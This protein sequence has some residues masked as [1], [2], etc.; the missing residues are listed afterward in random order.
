MRACFR[1][2]FF[3]SA[4]P[5]HQSCTPH[6][7]KIDGIDARNRN[8]A[9]TQWRLTNCSVYLLFCRQTT[10]I[11][12]TNPNIYEQRPQ[13]LSI[14]SGILSYGIILWSLSHD[15]IFYRKYAVVVKNFFNIL[16]AK[17]Q[18][19]HL[20]DS[21]DA[22]FL[23]KILIT[24]GN[25]CKNDTETFRHARCRAT[26]QGVL[27]RNSLN[28]SLRVLFPYDLLSISYEERISR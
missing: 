1:C 8:W 21:T 3:T 7:R 17:Q 25:S 23:M 5:I 26:L 2:I 22:N 4:Q 27:K 11:L 20:R 6:H 18:R 13:F 19:F 9:H 24:T 16:Q 28:I 14:P 10:H 15:F 12:E